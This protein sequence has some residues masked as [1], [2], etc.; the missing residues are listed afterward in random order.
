M[1]TCKGYTKRG[2]RCTKRVARG[3]Y[4]HNHVPY[5]HN[6]VPST[7]NTVITHTVNNQTITILSNGPIQVK[8]TRRGLEIITTT[9]STLSESSSIEE[10]STTSSTS[11][12]SSESSNEGLRSEESSNSSTE[13]QCSASSEDESSAEQHSIRC[14]NEGNPL[15]CPIC[16]G[17]ELEGMFVLKPCGHGMHQGCAA[18][19]K[20]NTCPYCR[21][22]VKNWN[23]STNII[24]KN[25]RDLQEQ[26]DYA[27]ALS[28]QYM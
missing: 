23:D 27:Y 10:I 13:E 7:T 20:Q 25:E 8:E 12:T 15:V 18:G 14:D 6:H 28:L 19:M 26:E 1:G 2:G 24:H 16:L 4:C 5:C 9:T 21:I 3:D 22:K 17:N 11:S